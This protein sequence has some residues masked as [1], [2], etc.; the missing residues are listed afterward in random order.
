MITAQGRVLLDRWVY[1]LVKVGEEFVLPYTAERLDAVRACPDYPPAFAGVLERVLE[2]L[3][4]PGWP[5]GSYYPGGWFRM[6][7]ARGGDPAAEP[8][9]QDAL[10]PFMLEEVRVDP[11]GR[12]WVEPKQMSGR[13]LEHF[14]RHLEYDAPVGR[15]RVRYRVEGVMEA[16]YLHHEAPPLRVMQV[17][18]GEAGPTVLLND[19][20]EEALRPDTLRLDAGEQLYCAVKPQALP[21]RFS[22]AARWALLKEGEES[23]DGWRL[24]LAGSAVV[25]P[26]VAD[27]PYAHPPTP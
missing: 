8:L 24:R 20:G 25:V 26:V 19:G 11:A 9:T 7:T 15:Y 18:E 27:W 14:L 22:D 13:V 1:V 16:R 17:R 4:A 6:R 3:Q 12:W 23:P 10:A 5:P 2:A 21:A